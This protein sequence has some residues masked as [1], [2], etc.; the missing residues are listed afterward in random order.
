MTAAVTM[1]VTMRD[2]LGAYQSVVVFG[3]TSDI[4]LETVR[5]LAAPGRLRHIAL[6][7]RRLSALEEAKAE[8][9]DLGVDDISLWEFDAQNTESHTLLI[10]EISAHVGDIDCAIIAFALLGTEHLGPIDP[11][12]ARILAQ[13]NYTGVVSIALPLTETMR[14]QGHGDVVF[15]SSVAGERVRAANFMYGSSKQAMDGFAQG[16][17]DSLQGSGV[18]VMV[19]RPGFVQTKMTTGMD[20]APFS[21]TADKVAADIVTGLKKR[22]EMVWSP[23]VMR[24]LFSVIRHLPRPLFRKMP[25]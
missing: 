8:L 21:T 10:A 11:E 18:H 5:Q 7:G 22:K 15:I 13:T 14:S 2:S 25:R 12:E 23:R 9:A 19:V 20:P 24:P 17:G 4:A 3:G 6:A 1:G 16:L